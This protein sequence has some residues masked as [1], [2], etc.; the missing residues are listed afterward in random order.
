MEYNHPDNAHKFARRL[1]KQRFSKV[2]KTITTLIAAGSAFLVF[3]GLIASLGFALLP[4]GL[5][6]LSV[7]VVNYI[8]FKEGVFNLFKFRTV[9]EVLK[10]FLL[11]PDYV[12]GKIK[13]EHPVKTAAITIFAMAMGLGF[14]LATVVAVFASLAT[15]AFFP[16]GIP[17]AIAALLGFVTL[18][19][20]NGVLN[21]SLRNNFNRVANFF[22]PHYDAVVKHF[23]QF[24][25][26]G[27]KN[28]FAFAMQSAGKALLLTVATVLVFPLAIAIF[29]KSDARKRLGHEWEEINGITN[30][31]EKRQAKIHFV[32]NLIVKSIAW[33]ALVIAAVLVT[34]VTLGSIHNSMNEFF[35][36]FL[37]QFSSLLAEGITLG[38]VGLMTVSEGTFN[39]ASMLAFVNSAFSAIAS[40]IAAPIVGA[41][42]VVAS[43]A[44]TKAAVEEDVKKTTQEATTFMKRLACDPWKTV[45]RVWE[46]FTTGSLYAL[47]A[48]NAF[49]NGVFATGGAFTLQV[50]PIATQTANV[51]SIGLGTVASAAAGFSFTASSLQTA[52]P[53]KVT[54]KRDTTQVENT[55]TKESDNEIA[56]AD[57]DDSTESLL[58]TTQKSSNPDT[59]FGTADY[60][61]HLAQGTFFT[62]PVSGESFFA[63]AEKAAAERRTAYSL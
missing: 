58:V 28:Q 55:L 41:S 32:T 45:G 26:E 22:K 30:Q 44:A 9:S 54:V 11:G 56:T 37:P 14:G 39:F 62:Q 10:A 24:P 51:A 23:K 60:D 4:A 21:S 13:D 50:V 47:C 63:I 12:N 3:N 18:V 19:G 1:S 49:G 27:L 16:P 40:L 35:G 53:T 20:F 52:P 5:I 31:K 59:Y 36:L 46:L 61:H 15:F 57:C 48:S 29:W 42:N 33:P 7:F 43:P 34:I 25:K 8:I 2:G 38:V 17:I 6:A